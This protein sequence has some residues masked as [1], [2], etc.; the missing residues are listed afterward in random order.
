MR[1]IHAVTQQ[2]TQYRT[3]GRCPHCPTC[4]HAAQETLQETMHI[5]SLS[6]PCI[7]LL[8]LISA[9]FPLRLTGLGIF[10]FLPARFALAFMGDD[11]FFIRGKFKGIQ[12][13]E[14]NSDLARVTLTKNRAQKEVMVAAVCGSG[15]IPGIKGSRELLYPALRPCCRLPGH[16]SPSEQQRLELRAECQLA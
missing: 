12:L 7:S 8:P 15:V 14:E 13:M 6:I 11:P 16:Q 4:T 9:S 1:S 5:K 10:L 3:F 2:F